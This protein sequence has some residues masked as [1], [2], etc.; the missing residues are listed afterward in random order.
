LYGGHHLKEREREMRISS[1]F[2]SIDGEVN[3]WGQGTFSTFIRFAG[4]SLSC[5]YCDTKWAQDKEGGTEYTVSDVIREVELYSS[6]NK[7]T[8]TG[9]EPLLQ[10]GAVEDLVDALL[11]K[12]IRKISIETNGAYFPRIGPT[13]PSALSWI[14]DYKLPSSKMMGKMMPLNLFSSL[15]YMDFIKMVVVTR[16][17]YEIARNLVYHFRTNTPARIAF[18]LGMM[19]GGQTPVIVPEELIQWM[20]EDRLMDCLVNFQLHKLIGLPED[21]DRRG[22]IGAKKSVKK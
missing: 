22:K 4:C 10:K 12:G 20:Q 5:S 17:D 11:I 3:W 1:I 19:K 13:A 9:G 18:S 14:V 2:N 7:V 16:E 21:S 8:I 15:G 6:C